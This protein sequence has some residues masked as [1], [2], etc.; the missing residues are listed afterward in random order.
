MA[1][2]WGIILITTGFCSACS[3]ISSPSSED[4]SSGNNRISFQIPLTSSNIQSS[5]A[6]DYDGIY[7]SISNKEARIGLSQDE[8]ESMGCT[9]RDR[10]DNSAALTYNMDGGERQ[11][12]LHMSSGGGAMLRFTKSFGEIKSKGREKCRV[13][14]KFQGVLGSSFNELFRRNTYTIGQEL[15]A[16]FGVGQ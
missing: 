2:V 5:L 11:L 15:R 4:T 10:F 7:H 6:G 14:S 12:S 16:K 9:L 1:L 13:A 3:S 8:A